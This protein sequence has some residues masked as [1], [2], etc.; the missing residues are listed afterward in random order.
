MCLWLD[1]RNTV[2]TQEA[3]VTRSCCYLENV[4]HSIALHLVY[5]KVLDS[6]SSVCVQLCQEAQDA[7]SSAFED[8]GQDDGVKD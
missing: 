6:L 7:V 2:V 4:G 8:M 5:Q 3:V 1:T